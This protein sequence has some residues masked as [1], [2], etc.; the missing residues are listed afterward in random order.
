MIIK[1]RLIRICKKVKYRK[2]VI[3]LRQLFVFTWSVFL[4]SAVFF[5]VS[6]WRRSIIG[7]TWTEFFMPLKHSFI[8]NCLNGDNFEKTKCFLSLVTL[9]KIYLLILFILKITFNVSS[10]VTNFPTLAKILA[11]IFF[12]NIVSCF[13]T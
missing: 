2:K 6:I 9:S 12:E 3:Y 10:S 13:C 5:D 8:V 1:L 11:K 4:N 7:N